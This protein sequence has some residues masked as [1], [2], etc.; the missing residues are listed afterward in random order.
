SGELLEV[1]PV[2]AEHFHLLGFKV[3]SVN[4]NT[5][6]HDRDWHLWICNPGYAMYPTQLHIPYFDH[7]FFNRTIESLAKGSDFNAFVFSKEEKNSYLDHI[8]HN[9]IARNA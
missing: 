3:D 4:I 9:T 6:Y 2:L 5:D 1:V 7:P 8:Y